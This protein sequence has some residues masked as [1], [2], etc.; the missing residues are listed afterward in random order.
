MKI[1]L[2]VQSA[3]CAVAL[4]VVGSKYWVSPEEVR[5]ENVTTQCNK[6][7][8]EQREEI[9]SA[10]DIQKNEYHNPSPL[11]RMPKLFEA[12]DGSGEKFACVVEGYDN[13]KPIISV[14]KIEI[15]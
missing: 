9:T 15:P 12:N 6:A 14:S 11:Y 10:M 3:F 1:P 7:A 5:I 8:Y 13:E 4:Q 2:S